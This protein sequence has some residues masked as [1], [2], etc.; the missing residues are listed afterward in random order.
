MLCTFYVAQGIP[1]AFTA[2][3]IP[4]YL[5]NHGASVAEVGGVLAMT[6]LPYAFKWIWGPI[7]D[8]FT[9]PRFG[10]RRPWIVFA[11]LMMALTILSMVLLPDLT[12]EV[13]TLTWVV[14]VH[15]VFNALQDVSV[16]ALA[17]DLLAE[18][19]RGRANGLMYASKYAGG[20]LGGAG[21]TWLI[22]ATS[23]RTALLAQSTVL[24]AIMIIPLTVRETDRPVEDRPRLRDTL[25]WL[26]DVFSVRSVIV[27]GVLMLTINLALGILTANGF[28]LFTHDLHWSESKLASLTG[29]I[30]L[31]IGFGG[32]VIAGLLA[33]HVGRKRLAAIASLMLACGWLVFGLATSL[34]TSDAFVY[35]MAILEAASSSI[36]TVTLFALCM[37]VSWPK[38]GA[39]QFAAYM[40]FANFSTTIGFR[41]APALDEHFGY[42]QIYLIAAGLQVVVTGTLVLIDPKQT[43]RE[44][45]RLEGQPPPPRGIAALVGFG[46]ILAVMTAFVAGAFG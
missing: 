8:S 21:L 13:Q 39:T 23:L 29:G 2:V 3:T 45:P 34:W 15:T 16:D 38:I 44:L 5:S 35:P 6:T 14:F 41:L 20:L 32:S 30:G 36:L 27:T 28:L 4:T 9:I 12:A 42:A 19:E 11:Q 7:I 40:A 31:A 24:F 37:D 22:H 10:R 46:A 1:W 43:A 25:R 17:I 33:D 26:V 18:N